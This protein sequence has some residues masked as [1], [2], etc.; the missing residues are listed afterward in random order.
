LVVPVKANAADRAKV[1]VNGSEDS[2]ANEIPAAGVS[3]AP[4]VWIWVES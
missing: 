4:P 3:V 1:S 2:R